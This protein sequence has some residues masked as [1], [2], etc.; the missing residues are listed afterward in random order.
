[1]AQEWHFLDPEHAL[2]KFGIQLVLS[3]PL[4]NNSEVITTNWSNSGMKTEFIRYMKSMNITT[5]WSNSGMKTEFIRC[6]KCVGAFINPNDMK[7]Y[8]YRPYL[9]M[10]AVLGISSVQILIW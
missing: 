1:V 3:Q 2:A 10:K 7:R 5:N 6:M 8:T 9:I 4:K